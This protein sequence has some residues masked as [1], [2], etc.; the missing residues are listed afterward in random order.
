MILWGSV[1][2]VLGHVL[3]SMGAIPGLA[4]GIRSTL[5]FSGL[6]VIA[7]ATGGIKP[8]VSSFAADQFPEE[9]HKERYVHN[10]HPLP[11]QLLIVITFF[12][13]Q[14]FSFFYFMINAGEE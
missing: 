10:T 4:M 7:I 14:F 1:V 2:Y 9:L 11:N 13:E 3:L 5:D 12:R 6:F 8:C